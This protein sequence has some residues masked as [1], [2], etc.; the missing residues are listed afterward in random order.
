[1][2]FNIYICR[3]ILSFIYL[4][5]KDNK[6]N[7][8]KIYKRKTNKFKKSITLCCESYDFRLQLE[9]SL[10]DGIALLCIIQT[11]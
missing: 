3:L 7:S 8:E 5:N 9:S 11:T 4:F 10:D 2:D 1:M 6:V